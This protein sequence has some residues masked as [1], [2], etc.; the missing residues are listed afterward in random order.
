MFD[1]ASRKLKDLKIDLAEIAKINPNRG[2][3]TSLKYEPLKPS[4]HEQITRNYLTTSVTR[5]NSL[6]TTLL[7]NPVVKSVY[8]KE[9]SNV[10]KDYN[11]YESSTLYKNDAPTSTLSYL[12]FYI[13]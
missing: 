9:S 10:K 5:I 3:N 1:E 2:V 13:N 8:D 12:I 7:D 11:A 4:T 6:A